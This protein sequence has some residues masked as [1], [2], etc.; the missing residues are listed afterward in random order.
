MTYAAG[1]TPLSHEGPGWFQHQPQDLQPSQCSGCRGD[2]AGHSHTWSMRCGPEHLPNSCSE[3]WG[4]FPKAPPE[5]VKVP[6]GPPLGAPG[7]HP[8][9]QGFQCQARL[10]PGDQEDRAPLPPAWLS[11]ALRPPA[12]LTI[13]PL[14]GPAVLPDTELFVHSRGMRTRERASE[15]HR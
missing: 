12:P 5:R 3:K 8:F 7:V 4:V 1:V 6:R 10:L 13:F 11:N 15:T 14:A 9:P 2:G